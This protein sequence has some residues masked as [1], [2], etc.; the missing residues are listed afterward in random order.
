M[1]EGNDG[2]KQHHHRMNE[3]ED[4][5]KLI[6]DSYESQQP[7]PP[8]ADL[9]WQKIKVKTVLKPWYKTLAGFSSI[10]AVVLVLV[11]G[12]IWVGSEKGDNSSVAKNAAIHQ[13]PAKES[14]QPMAIDSNLNTIANGTEKAMSDSSGKNKSNP[15]VALLFQEKN[16]VNA[17]KSESFSD[18]NAAKTPNISVKQNDTNVK[19]NNSANGLPDNGVQTTASGDA[20]QGPGSRAMWWTRASRL[21]A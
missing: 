17:T 6:R 4:F 10:V 11:T 12:W 15:N 5:K 16:A 7:E 9:L 1:A 20:G 3:A 18:R 14:K 19:Q 21:P 8:D 13:E 2:Q